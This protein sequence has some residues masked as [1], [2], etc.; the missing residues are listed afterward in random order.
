MSRKGPVSSSAPGGGGSVSVPGVDEQAPARA[1]SP[2]QITMRGVQRHIRV[3][4]QN[5]SPGGGRP[6]CSVVHTRS[7]RAYPPGRRTGLSAGSDHTSR[8]TDPGE[9]A[10]AFTPG[11]RRRVVPVDSTSTR[12][13]F[14][15]ACSDREH[16]LRVVAGG[17]PEVDERALPV[18]P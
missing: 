16:L 13:H 2:V 4:V 3:F 9:G 8:S 6:D 11:P 12:G 7:L 1:R 18:M 14:S 15:S 10:P 17:P 5:R